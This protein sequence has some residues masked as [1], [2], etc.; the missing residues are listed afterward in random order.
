MTISQLLQ[1][2]KETTKAISCALDNK[3]YVLVDALSEKIYSLADDAED[4]ISAIERKL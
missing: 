4:N 3:D 1:R 2:I